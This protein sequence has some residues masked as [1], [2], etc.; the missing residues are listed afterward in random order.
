MYPRLPLPGVAHKQQEHSKVSECTRL[1]R[2]VSKLDMAEV[3]VGSAE[4]V[5]QLTVKDPLELRVAH[6]AKD[7]E[8]DLPGEQRS[9]APEETSHALRLRGHPQCIQHVIVPAHLSA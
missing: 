2:R 1:E 6:H 8:G 3:G 4:Q 5:E 9:C 7:I